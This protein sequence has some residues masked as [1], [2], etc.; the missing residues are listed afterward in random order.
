LYI[1]IAKGIR[2]IIVVVNKMDAIQYSKDAFENIC[3]KVTNILKEVQFQKL[4]NVVFVPVS[5]L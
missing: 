1:A 3:C 2:H 5:G 4:E